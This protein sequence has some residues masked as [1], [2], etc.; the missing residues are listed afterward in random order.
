MSNDAQSQQQQ[1]VSLVYEFVGNY[2]N[3]QYTQIERVRR[4][5]IWNNAQI[6]KKTNE[7]EAFFKIFLFNL[8]I[9]QKRKG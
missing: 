4:E 6:N 7:G 5:I 2:R 8:E 3:Q 9:K 1:S